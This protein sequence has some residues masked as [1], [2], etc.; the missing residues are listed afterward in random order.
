MNTLPN[1]IIFSVFQS[2]LSHNE[3]MLHHLETK[4]LL[5]EVPY[6]IVNGVYKNSHELSFVVI[7]HKHLELVLSIASHFKQETIL[8]SYSDRSSYLMNVSSHFETYIGKFKA[9]DKKTALASQNYTYDT[10]TDQYF[11][12]EV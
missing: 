11:I 2:D 4:E 8:K 12:C 7:G 6:K 1:I 9:T 5:K 3:N 10:E